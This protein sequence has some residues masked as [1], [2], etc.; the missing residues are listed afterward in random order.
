LKG[1]CKDLQVNLTGVGSVANAD[2]V[3]ENCRAS[4]NGVG[5]AEVNVTGEL[6][7][8]VTGVG[9]VSYKGNPR[10][11]SKSVSGLGGVDEM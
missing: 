1:T 10:K 5:S 6:D 3:S 4:V 8:S 9:K 7:A 2:L 11:L